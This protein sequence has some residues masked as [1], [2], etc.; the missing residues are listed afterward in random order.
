MLDRNKRFVDK[1]ALITGA[2][3]VIGREVAINMHAEGAYEV[4]VDRSELVHELKEQCQVERIHTLTAD[5]EQFEG[6][7][8]AASTAHEVIG[9]IDGLINDV[10]GTI[11][12]RPLEHYEAAQ[13]EKEVDRRR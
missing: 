7:Q 5:L 4:A 12:T 6:A 9:R 3:H 1:V 13:V 2:A 11:W 10:G 8:Y